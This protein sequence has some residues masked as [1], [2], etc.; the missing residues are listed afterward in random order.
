MGVSNSPNIDA[1]GVVSSILW[2]L[3]DN[4]V[5]VSPILDV[6]PSNDRHT[7]A[8]EDFSD[9]GE[10]D[11]SSTA[12]MRHWLPGPRN[13]SL[14][15]VKS[16]ARRPPV[17]QGTLSFCCTIMPYLTLHISSSCSSDTMFEETYEKEKRLWVY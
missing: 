6:S 13:I 4:V 2:D 12:S 10:S 7:V 3:F 17:A 8:Y 11:W 16:L 5:G 14:L 9:G 15:G 1:E